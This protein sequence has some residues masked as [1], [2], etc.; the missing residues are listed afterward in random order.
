MFILKLLKPKKMILSISS[1]MILLL[2]SLLYNTCFIN[3]DCIAGLTWY[4]SSN[5]CVVG[6]IYSNHPKSEWKTS[7]KTPHGL[8][9]GL[10]AFGLSNTLDT[11]IRCMNQVLR[12]FK[13]KHKVVY[14]NDINLWHYAVTSWQCL[15]QGM[16]WC[17]LTSRSA[18][19]IKK[20]SCFFW[21]CGAF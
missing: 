10:M 17:T 8:I 13:R 2:I 14:F 5:T 7:F 6:T 16:K 19:L 15:S 3:L 4:P 1:L 18:H 9:N 11:F 21:T 20:K 12:Q